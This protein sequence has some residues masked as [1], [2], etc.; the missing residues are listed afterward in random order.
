MDLEDLESHSPPQEGNRERSAGG[1]SSGTYAVLRVPE[2][3][4]VKKQNHA[5]WLQ[6]LNAVTGIDDYIQCEAR[7]RMIEK[8][9]GG[10]ASKRVHTECAK[11]RYL[12][13]KGSDARIADE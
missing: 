5:I 4:H 2:G 8:L 7:G 1:G 9:T 10:R 11:N 3:K 12:Q 13:Q 6:M